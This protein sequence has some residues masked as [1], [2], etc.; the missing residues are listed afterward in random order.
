MFTSE[1]FRIFNSIKYFKL[2]LTVSILKLKGKSQC[3]VRYILLI[4]RIRWRFCIVL[5]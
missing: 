5:F 4:I 1:Y 3:K 2:R